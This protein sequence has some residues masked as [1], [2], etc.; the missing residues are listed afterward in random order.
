MSLECALEGDCGPRPPSFSFWLPGYEV[1]GFVLSCALTM[2]HAQNK[3][4][5]QSWTGISKT[6]SQNK[7]TL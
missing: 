7:T 5:N 6:V 2:T 1:S 4:A 3:E